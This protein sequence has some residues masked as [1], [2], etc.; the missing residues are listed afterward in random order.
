MA[1]GTHCEPQIYLQNLYY[2]CT[3]VNIFTDWA[4][5]LMQDLHLQV[6]VLSLMIR[7]PIP[8]LWKVQMHRNT[9]ILVTGILGLGI[10]YVNTFALADPC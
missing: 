5:A 9:N 1:E 2:C 7:R 6:T 8:L 10:F 3:L 4:T